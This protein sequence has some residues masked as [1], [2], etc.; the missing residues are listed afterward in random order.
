MA[1]SCE[2]Y[3]EIMADWVPAQCVLVAATTLPGFLECLLTFFTPNKTLT[4]LHDLRKRQDFCKKIGNEKL[5]IV[6]LPQKNFEVA[7]GM[8]VVSC[9]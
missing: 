6:D 2:R 5:D 7:L 8:P 1:D 4:L 3:R 9:L